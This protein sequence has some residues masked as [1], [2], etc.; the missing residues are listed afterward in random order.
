MENISTAIKALFRGI[1]GDEILKS[2][3]FLDAKGQVLHIDAA[4]EESMIV[5]RLLKEDTGRT[6]DQISMLGQ[7]IQ[8]KWMEKDRTCMTLKFHESSSVFNLLLYF[9]S[10]CLLVNTGDPQVQ[11]SYLLRWHLLT[12]PLGEDLLPP[13]SLHRETFPWSMSER[14]LTGMHFLVII[15]KN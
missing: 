1:S 13:H 2:A 9:T 6:I 8:F 10:K 7:I 12:A 5:K 15:V 14:V 4:I 3:G 11:Y